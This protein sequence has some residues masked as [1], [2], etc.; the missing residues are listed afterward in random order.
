MIVYILARVILLHYAEYTGI[1]KITALLLLAAELFIV[2]HG[3]GYILNISRAYKKNPSDM[4][5]MENE[6]PDRTSE[7][8]AAVLLAARHEPKELLEETLNSIKNLEYS[9]KDIY[10]LDDSSMDKYRTEAEEI[11]RDM[12]IKLFR[13]EK[14][15]G[16]K[17]GIINDCL[18]TLDHKYVA[19]FD[20]DQNPLPTFLKKIIPIM[21]KNEK[22]AFVQAP[23]F[24]TNIRESRVARAAAF[25]LAV[26]Y[27][28]IC[29]GK[30]SQDAMFCCGTNIVFRREALLDVG[31]L[32]EDTVT[33]DFA[34]SLK[35]H[36]KKWRSLYYNH[37]SAFG[38][39]PRNLSSYFKQQYRWANGTVTVLKR[40]AASFIKE[41]FALSFRQWWEYFLSGSY[42]FVGL[43]FFILMSFPIAY[44]LF[45]VP[46]Y[47][48]RPEIYVLTF[49][50][51]I[52][53]SAAVFYFVLEGRNYTMKD[54]FIGQFLG[55]ISFPVYL[56][57]TFSALAGRSS[58][59]GITDKTEGAAVPYTVMWPQVTF[60]V[61]NY[62]A[63]VWGVN[64]FLYERDPAIIVNIF[65]AVF[66]ILILC[67]VFYF[68]YDGGLSSCKVLR[69]GLSFDYRKVETE[70]SLTGLAAQTWKL[71]FDVFMPEE[72]E[73]G[74]MLMCRVRDGEGEA[75]VFDAQVLRTV[76]N[77]KKGFQ[78]KLGV[79]TIT[80]LDREKMER[81]FLR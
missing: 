29:E 7:P 19:I 47:F 63:V 20:A 48:A 51:Y 59:F 15:H 27:E 38:M 67:S 77:K 21:E 5:P 55:G 61:I 70:Q 14:R 78:V 64:R 65:W 17:A 9:R 37:V 30:S 81:E 40:T 34:T 41:P 12:D 10:L 52:M 44:L 31:G 75:V 43:A 23:Q 54:I 1:D 58:G 4:G 13:R 33:E 42:Y 25:Q 24:Y 53:L 46:S 56:R 69:K 8:P 16:A 57:A 76:R 35:L 32:D 22:M 39:A 72:T 2:I 36:Q 79:A 28:Y 71:C 80:S 74:K 6:L 49:M 11:A 66:H 60:L 50:P 68:N 45:N 26:F 3:V 62:V 73:P 18:K